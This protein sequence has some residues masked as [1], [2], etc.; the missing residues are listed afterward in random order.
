MV[1]VKT[2]EYKE[3]IDLLFVEANPI[4]L[5]KALQL[6]GIIKSA[7]CRLPLVTLSDTNTEKLK[8]VMKQKGLLP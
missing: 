5:K 4:P 3:L 1:K 7:E 8:K 6:M 2:K